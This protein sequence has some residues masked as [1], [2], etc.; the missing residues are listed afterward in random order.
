MNAK[1]KNGEFAGVRKKLTAAV[2][3]LL[4]AT[5]MMASSTYAWFTL[6][7][8]PEVT[9]ITTSVGANGNLEMALATKDGAAPGTSGVGDSNNSQTWGNLVNIGDDYGL[10]N[11]TLKPSQ[12][13][14]VN[15]T[16]STN[17]LQVPTYGADGRVDR[18]NSTTMSGVFDSSKNG[19]VA[20][21]AIYGVRGLGQSTSMSETEQT[22][23]TALIA[24]ENFVSTAKSTTNQSITQYGNTL[25][26]MAV[27]HG[28]NA[29]KSED[30]YTKSEVETINSVI[31]CLTNAKNTIE[32][33]LMNAVLVAAASENS[34][35]SIYDAVNKAMAAD[36]AS[37]NSVETAFT[38]A[39]NEA[40]YVDG[41][42][43][44][45]LPDGYNDAKSNWTAITIPE[46]ITSISEDSEGNVGTNSWDTIQGALNAIVET[47]GIT[48]NG[49]TIDQIKSMESLD[50]LIALANNATLE[51]N[52]GSGIYGQIAVLV[53]NIGANIGDIPVKMD[54]MQVTARSVYMK[55]TVTETALL[56][57]LGVKLSNMGALSL[58]DTETSTDQIVNDLYA[59]AVDLWF[60]TNASG[61]NL[62]LQT[63]ATNRI[64]KNGGSTE[65]MGGGSTYTFTVPNDAISLDTARKLAACIHVVFTDREGNVL[66]VAG[67]DTANLTETTA[68][69]GTVEYTAKLYMQK[70]GWNNDKNT[71]V[72]TY[73][74]ETIETEVKTKV[75]SYGNPIIA[76]DT[77]GVITALNQN[78]AKMISA[79]VYLDGTSVDNSMV[80]A[81]SNQSLTGSLNLQFGS[82][83][84]LKPMDYSPLKGNDATSEPET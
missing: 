59:F 25:A 48:L 56:K 39:L 82:S 44:V 8:A 14:I 13:N 23:Y 18:L 26:Q 15:G 31:D 29:E 41:A 36:N 52:A 35:K 69:N 1:K 73:E 22:L 60:R 30:V 34:T 61:S 67:L 72:Y 10:N 3:M 9:G 74:T 80:A 17:P 40:S 37:L 43:M 65:T 55:T 76:K 64:Y 20:G 84:E 5:I 57:T 49:K 71:I 38:T 54:G 33:A 58:S 4:V 79:Y 63:D 47:D 75:D 53:G 24:F 62:L 51:M 6:S 19:F 2:A 66:A 81:T 42:N 45:T 50:D 28:L 16:V 77:T 12:L 70:W 27:R 21:S 11:I 83:A 32:K 46:K 78:E 68:E 7:T